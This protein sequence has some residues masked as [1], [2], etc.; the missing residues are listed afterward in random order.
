MRPRKARLFSS[1][2]KQG[3]VPYGPAGIF[4]GTIVGYHSFWVSLPW[5]WGHSLEYLGHPNLN[6]TMI[7]PQVLPEYLLRLLALIILAKSP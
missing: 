5:D 4:W 6:P 3:G 1:T 7:L 2:G